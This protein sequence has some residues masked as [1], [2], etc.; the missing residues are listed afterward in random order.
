[1]NTS[2]SSTCAGRTGQALQK[3]LELTL[4]RLSEG[5]G[6]PVR[7]RVPS[8]GGREGP[9]RSL[10]RGGGNGVLTVP[11]R[12]YAASFDAYRPWFAGLYT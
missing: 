5:S 9:H 1:M 4:I 10:L 3:L 12:R 2:G 11:I 7:A 8:A 6:V